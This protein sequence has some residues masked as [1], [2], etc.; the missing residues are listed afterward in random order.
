MSGTNVPNGPSLYLRKKKRLKELFSLFSDN[1]TEKN[2]TEQHKLLL[3][4]LNKAEL[5]TLKHKIYFRFAQ[6]I[7]GNQ[8][9]LLIVNKV[10][11]VSK[12]IGDKF[13]CYWNEKEIVQQNEIDE[14]VNALKYVISNNS[15]KTLFELDKDYTVAHAKEG[16]A[17][18][19]LCF[20]TSLNRALLFPNNPGVL[21]SEI[22][23]H[24]QGIQ[25]IEEYRPGFIHAIQAVQHFSFSIVSK[26]EYYQLSTRI[27]KE[28]ISTI[29]NLEHNVEPFFIFRRINKG[30]SGLNSIRNGVN[31]NFKTI[32]DIDDLIKVMELDRMSVGIQEFI[33]K[34]LQRRRVKLSVVGEGGHG[35]T[36]LIRA[37]SGEHFENTLSTQS[38]ERKD[39]RFPF[40]SNHLRLQNDRPWIKLTEDHMQK[41]EIGSIALR[42]HDDQKKQL[43]ELEHNSILKGTTGDLNNS[44][45]TK[46]E[47]ENISRESENIIPNSGT[48]SNKKKQEIVSLEGTNIISIKEKEIGT[49]KEF[50]NKITKFASESKEGIY[51]SVWD[52]AGQETYFSSHRFL[53]TESH[54]VFLLVVNLNEWSKKETIKKTHWWYKSIQQHSP[55]VIVVATHA[56]YFESNVELLISMRSLR[57]SFKNMNY[58]LAF[59]L[60]NLPA[61]VFTFDKVNEEANIPSTNNYELLN[62]KREEN[63]YVKWQIQIRDLARTMK[64]SFEKDDWKLGIEETREYIFEQ[65]HSQVDKKELPAVWLYYEHEIL[66]LSKGKPVIDRSELITLGKDCY[67]E[68]E[69]CNDA[70]KYF[71]YLGE[72]LL[73]ENRVGAYIDKKS[74]KGLK[75]KVVINSHWLIECFKLIVI[76]SDLDYEFKALDDNINKLLREG[77]ITREYIQFKYDTP[78]L[79]LQLSEVDTIINL[80]R[81]YGVIYT[82]ES[83]QEYFHAPYLMP[84]E[85]LSFQYDQNQSYLGTTNNLASL[86]YFP[87]LLTM[88]TA[89]DLIV[90]SLQWADSDE[91]GHRHHHPWRNGVWWKKG[92]HSIQVKIIPEKDSINIKVFGP[93]SLKVAKNVIKLLE[94]HVL[95]PPLLLNANENSIEETLR[96]LLLTLEIPKEVDDKVQCI[97][98]GIKK[99]VNEVITFHIKEFIISGSYSRNTALYPLHDVD[100]I[101]VLP[102]AFRGELSQKDV[103]DKLCSTLEDKNVEFKVNGKKFKQKITRPRTQTRSIGFEFDGIAFDI[104]PA[105]KLKTDEDGTFEIADR[106]LSEWIKTT[107]KKHKDLLNNLP[108]SNSFKEIIILIK[109][110]LK[111][112]QDKFKKKNKDLADLYKVPSF[113]MEAMIISCKTLHNYYS[114]GSSHSLSIALKYAFDHLRSNISKT[115]ELYSVTRKDSQESISLKNKAYDEVF[116]IIGNA[117]KAQKK[118]RYRAALLL[119]KSIFPNLF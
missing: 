67:L 18:V 39:F 68:E 15:F 77:I 113:R 102:N 20:L 9:L 50:L 86:K 35:K 83:K 97:I 34:K 37:L 8:H 57:E 93:N 90:C 32:T 19:H 2:T 3:Q 66:E 46:Q 41:S 76:R 17:D 72:I 108:N 85:E 24:L 12:K 7:I 38:V 80:L 75:N 31:P 64:E 63:G 22:N 25:E 119:W 105:F 44:N 96:A 82:H 47:H 53:F 71:S 28:A 73:Y 117:N 99:K 101:V 69:E 1:L 42:L 70:L 36:C 51:V 98:E 100:L 4:Q 55:H 104:V 65:L 116:K 78:G 14:L 6:P 21:F 33:E 103:L 110:W 81:Y 114:E 26:I 79:K 115:P 94:E 45:K 58:P 109:Y 40:S 59:C 74:A 91:D 61:E 5:P 87:N 62:E 88:G 92:K 43:E 29:Q 48:N 112:Q 16:I 11:G 13:E 118:G 84:E 107:P 95:C 106:D 27:C 52:F 30:L 89:T 10:E 54:S 23:P 111:Q 60:V 49:E 56:D